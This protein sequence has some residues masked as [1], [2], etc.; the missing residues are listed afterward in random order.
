MSTARHHAEWLSLVEQSGPFLSMPVLLR[1]LPQGLDAHDPEHH[2]LLKLAHQ[3]WEEASDDPAVHRAW[4]RFVLTQTLE[5]PEEVLAE[6]QAVANLKH[7]LPEH[8]ETLRPD[9]AVMLD[10]K[11]HLLVKVYLPGQDLDR[12]PAGGNWKASCGTRMMELLHAIGVRLGLVINGERWMLVDAPRGETTGFASWYASYWLEEP[13]TLR[14]FRTLLSARRFFSVPEGETLAAMLAESA[15]NQQEV[16]D[17]LGY[18]VRRAVEVLIQSLDRADQDHGRKLLGRVPEA[19]LYEAALTVMMRLVFLFSTE[20]RAL[21]ALGDPL[22]DEH[23]A[24]ST[25]REQLRGDADQHGEEVLERRLDAWVRLLATFRA[26]HGGVEHHRLTLP[27]YGGHLFDPDRFPFLEG[28]ERD[29]RWR[30]SPASPLPV[31]NRTVLHLLEALQLLQVKVPGGGPAEARRLSFRALDIEQIGHVYEGLLDHTARRAAEP[32]LGLAGTKDLEPEVALAELE[33]QRA[34]GEQEFLKFLKGETGRSESALKKAL[35]AT[36]EGHEAGR[37]RTACGNDAALWERVRPFAGLVR[38]DTFGH[39]VVIPAGSVYV[40]EGTDRRASGTHYTPRSLTE[41]IVRYTLEPLVYDGPAEG[42]PP[43]RWRLKPSRDLLGLKVCDMATGSGAFLVQA[44]R[45]LSERLLEAWEQAERGGGGRQGTLDF[46]NPD[47]ASPAKGRPRITPFGEVARGRLDEQ[48]IPED[49]GDRAVYAR[50]LVAQRCLYGVDKNPVAVEMAKLSL[51]LLTLAKGQPF[52]FLDHAI[53]CGDSLVGIHDL[54]QLRKLHF[55]LKSQSQYLLSCDMRAMVNE[56]V[57]LRL[58]IEEMQADDIEDVEAQ[59]R[60]LREAEEKMARLRYSADI[61]TAAE[62]KPAKA[63]ER[64][65]LRD[66]AAIRI[67]Y[68]VEDGTLDEFRQAARKDLAGQNPFHWPLEF[69]EVFAR[70]GGFDA[71]VGNP[72]FMG[73]LRLETAFGTEWRAFLVD[74][75]AS[76]VRGVRGTADLCSYFFLRTSQ[77]L[78]PMGTC[79]LLATNTIAQGDSRTVGLDQIVHSGNAIYRCVPSMKWPG[80][81]SLEVAQVWLTKG[82]WVGHRFIDDIQVASITPLL[83]AQDSPSSKPYRLKANQSLCFQGS[84]LVGTGFL[85]TPDEAERLR[86]AEPSAKYV[87]YPYLSGEDLNT[88]PQQLASRIAI[89]FRQWP[90]TRDGSGLGQAAEDYPACLTIIEQKVK[91]E[92]MQYEP[93]D[94]WNKGLRNK[95]WQFAAWRPNLYSAIEQ[96]ETVIVVAATSRTLAFAI[97]PAKRVFAHTTYVVASGDTSL[98]AVLQST[99]AASWIRQYA[100]SLKGDLRFTPSEC[101][102]TLPRPMGVC[103]SL[104]ETGRVYNEA[105]AQLMQFGNFGLT[106]LYNRFHNRDET[107][108]DITSL[109]QLHVE[110]DQAVAAAYGWTDLDLGDGFHQTRQGVRYT[111]SETARREVLARLLKLNHER[112]ADEVRQGLHE[113]KKGTKTKGRK[114]QETTGELFE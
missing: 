73:G 14:A 10:G 9:Y 89:N 62:L 21:L 48:I 108:T 5:M 44:C 25:L 68:Y 32:M 87:L 52:T 84:I 20:E 40:T 102:E 27:A 26:V 82:E 60:L 99:I 11:P 41:P 12:A 17:Q 54:E 19:E 85:L 61:L 57:D 69:P 65:G 23:Y 78:R 2:Q 16:T 49:A 29:T 109:R 100:S 105:R 70:R 42:K 104:N 39:P 35:A 91:P 79:G 103:S 94:A 6:G 33:M 81:A 46:D 22:Y 28:R 95:W 58:R 113:A 66:D 90:L 72:P 37:F 56:G 71:F 8:G 67:G 13:I 110:M 98:F 1:V 86:T 53:R 111:V 83:T 31:N 88:H 4:V 45:Y 112:Y 80:V 30:D 43:D 63:S 36:F 92:R 34:G 47:G 51:W 114:K 106:E 93:K 101:F 24:V 74:W 59:E 96:L 18:Q 64:E 55:D 38:P 75:L 15:S 7:D 97:V 50:R 3:E 77:L 76:G 107:T